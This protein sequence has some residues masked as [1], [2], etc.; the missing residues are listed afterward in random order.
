MRRLSIGVCCVAL[1]ALCTLSEAT[2][3][4]GETKEEIALRLAVERYAKVHRTTYCG[5]AQ[6]P[7]LKIALVPLCESIIEAVVR[8][9]GMEQKKSEAEIET[10]L[11]TAKKKFLQGQETI[12]VLFVS[13][14]HWDDIGEVRL[15]SLKSN[16]TL[17]DEFGTY[18]LLRFSPVF[19]A[20]LKQG[21]T[22]GYLYFKKFRNESM[23]Y[24]VH[25]GGLKIRGRTCVNREW[26]FY[27]WAMSFDNSKV[28]FLALLQK[29][30]DETYLRKNHGILGDLTASDII[31][32]VG[33][34]V[35]IAKI[36]L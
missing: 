11:A 2:G 9:K 23:S 35:D 1:L 12:F 36:M 5:D 7:R 18:P 24:S 26:K 29:G 25:F 33:I 28:D 27:D 4:E 6:D 30:L 14:R 8:L 21:T 10:M 16:I 17:R 34:M 13:N 3:R 31:T 20:R 15:E 32:I 22:S 19:D